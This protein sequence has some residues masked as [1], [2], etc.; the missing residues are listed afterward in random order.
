MLG[1]L[2]N[3]R[4]GKRY[5]G[6]VKLALGKLNCLSLTEKVLEDT[7]V[8]LFSFLLQKNNAIHK[9]ALT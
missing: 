5:A 3:L 1:K 7:F 8:F 9:Q 2:G 6:S 4:P